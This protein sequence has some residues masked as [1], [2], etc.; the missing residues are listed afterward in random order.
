M[1]RDS[2]THTCVVRPLQPDHIWNKPMVLVLIRGGG[3]GFICICVYLLF[4]YLLRDRRAMIRYRVKRILSHFLDID[5][6]ICINYCLRV[7][8]SAGIEHIH[9]ISH[10]QNCYSLPQLPH[11]LV[12]FLPSLPANLPPQLCDHL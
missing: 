12:L 3:C 6:H 9:I 2:L 5:I 8:R 11:N 1:W 10:Q 4:I 7:R